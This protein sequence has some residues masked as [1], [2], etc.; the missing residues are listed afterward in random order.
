MKIIYFDEVTISLYYTLKLK[1]IIFDKKK[2][3][4]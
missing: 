2:L 1:P 4:S 3:Y